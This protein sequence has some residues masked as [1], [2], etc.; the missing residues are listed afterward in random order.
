[1]TPSLSPLFFHVKR[2]IEQQLSGRFTAEL[3]KLDRYT[4]LRSNKSIDFYLF[5]TMAYDNATK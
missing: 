4:K 5:V 2:I 3:E 1:M